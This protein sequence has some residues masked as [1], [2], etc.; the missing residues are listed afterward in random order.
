MG[1]PVNDDHHIDVGHDGALDKMIIKRVA[2]IIKSCMVFLL[3]PPFLHFHCSFVKK[4][5]GAR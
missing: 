3:P 1:H 4:E 2:E 5:V